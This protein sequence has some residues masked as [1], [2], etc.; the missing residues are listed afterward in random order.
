MLPLSRQLQQQVHQPQWSLLPQAPLWLRHFLAKCHI[1]AMDAQIALLMDRLREEVM[2]LVIRE[3]DYQRI[4]TNLPQSIV[5][6]GML[7][8][9]AQFV[10]N[11]L[12][13]GTGGDQ[14]LFRLWIYVQAV[15]CPWL[16]FLMRPWL[17]CMA[18]GQW[19][20]NKDSRTVSNGQKL[21]VLI[22]QL[23]PYSEE[24]IMWWDQNSCIHKFLC[25]VS[26]SLFVL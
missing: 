22:S 19:Q 18:V 8:V 25:S 6:N 16:I 1:T 13:C 3:Q 21:I 7:L 15:V 4:S 17:I 23:I 26:Y 10:G 14:R 5:I 9:Q 11:A 12:N 2:E 20:L 24:V